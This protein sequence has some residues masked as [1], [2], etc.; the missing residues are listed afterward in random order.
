MFDLIVANFNNA[1]FLNVFFDSIQNSTLLPQKIIFVDDC[2]TD[3]SLEIVDSYITQNKLDILLI[4]NVRNMGFAES[5]NIAISNISSPYFA[6]LDPDDYVKPERFKLQL[7]FIKSN[8]NIDL[9]GTNVIY[10]LKGKTKSTSNVETNRKIIQ[11][12]IIKG[13]LPLIHGSI[14]GRSKIIMNYKYNQDLVPAED[15]DLFAFLIKN[16]IS[17]TN[18]K[19]PLTYV[20]IHENSVS[21][22]LKFSTVM[23]RY[24]ICYKYFKINKSFIGRFL[25]YKQ[26]Y[27]Y[28]KFLYESTM[29]KYYYL[30]ISSILNPIKVVKK[31]TNIIFLAL[32]K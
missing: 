24:D 26:L 8:Q 3:N 14:F 22:D 2:S 5:L 31:L 20:N 32:K 15:Y 30:I 18:L 1:K 4:K 6:R 25:E 10:I 11:K 16:G 28:R 12:K 21:N 9:V 29:L 23:K 17:I 19:T 27:F 7:E 13:V